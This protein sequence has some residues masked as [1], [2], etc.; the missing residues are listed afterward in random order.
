MTL[1][2]FVQGMGQIEVNCKEC[3]NIKVNDGK[4]KLM[5]KHLIKIW[6]RYSCGSLT[7]LQYNQ[8]IPQS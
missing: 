7:T 6:K 3:L 4:V 1:I 5:R 2:W 8:Y